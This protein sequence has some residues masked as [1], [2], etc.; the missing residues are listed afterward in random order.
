MRVEEY[1]PETDGDRAKSSQRDGESTMLKCQ[2]RQNTEYNDGVRGVARGE[3]VA[4]VEDCSGVGG[5]QGAK[6]TDR[7]FHRPNTHIEQHQRGDE[8]HYRPTRTR[9]PR[10]PKQ[11]RAG[12]SCGWRPLGDDF[13]AQHPWLEVRPM[14]RQIHRGSTTVYAVQR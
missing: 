13:I 10:T 5:Q 11:V 1:R 2:D 7:K 6:A 12:N 9:P 8:H 14:S 3:N 4:T